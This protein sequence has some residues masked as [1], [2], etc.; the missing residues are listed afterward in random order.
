MCFLFPLPLSLLSQ[1]ESAVCVF[2]GQPYS[3]LTNE[4]AESHNQAMRREQERVEKGGTDRHSPRA[5]ARR[6]PISR[7]KCVCVCV[8]VCVCERGVCK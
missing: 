3:D 8:C 5:V 4:E 6:L 2:S 1:G 7:A